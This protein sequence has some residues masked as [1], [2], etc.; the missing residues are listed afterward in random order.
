MRQIVS[1]L[2]SFSIQGSPPLLE[3]YHTVVIHVHFVKELVE[4]G[5]GYRETSSSKCRLQLTLV[6][7]AVVIAIDAFKEL[8]ELPLGV[9]NEDLELC[10]AASA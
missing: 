8:P 4:L 9:F 6:K 5:T 7:F 2:H 3:T 1:I 10:D